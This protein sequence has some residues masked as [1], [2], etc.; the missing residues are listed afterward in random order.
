MS[1]RDSE[2]DKSIRM[3]EMSELDAGGGGEAA[4]GAE[5]NGVAGGA[6]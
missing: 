6:G 2:R 1:D 5:R 4:A 3:S